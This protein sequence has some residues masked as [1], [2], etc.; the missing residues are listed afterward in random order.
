MRGLRSVVIVAA[1]AALFAGSCSSDSETTSADSTD[2]TEATTTTAAP[3][4]DLSKAGP[5]DVGRTTVTFADPARD[6]REV[7][8]DIWYPADPD[9]AAGADASVYE[10]ISGISAESETALAEPAVS[11]DGPFPLIVYSHG[12]GGVR[13]ISAF[14]SEQLASHGFVVAAP[15]HAGNTVFDVVLESEDEPDVVRV[16][17]PLDVS[18]VISSLTGDAVPE[19]V[20]GTI[21]DQSIGVVGHSFGAY[22]ALVTPGGSPGVEPDPRV[23]AVVALAPATERTPDEVLAALGVPTLLVAGTAD[24]TTPIDPD[25]E[26]PWE[27]VSGRPLERVDLVEGAHQSFS[28]VCWAKEIIDALPDVSPVIVTV[29]DGNAEEGCT[30]E[31][32]DI[33]DAHAIVNAAVTAFFLRELSGGASSVGDAVDGLGSLADQAEV[34]AKN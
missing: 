24:I 34:S 18:F 20:A 4:V 32:M 10:F 30:P 19:V 23:G 33:D 21:D 26:R 14:L 31:L 28:D 16:N 9:S 15:D 13:F 1:A 6:G 5:Y 8:T 3:D 27:L 7:T 11:S 12:N 17:R 22:T 29:V 2:S 25:T